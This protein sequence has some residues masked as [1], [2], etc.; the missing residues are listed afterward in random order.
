MA[1][2]KIRNL[3]LAAVALAALPLIARA[4]PTSTAAPAA[5][6]VPGWDALVDS[7][8]KLPERMLAKLPPAMQ[9]DPQV[10]QEVARLALE[11]VASSTLETIGADGDAPVFLPSIGQVLNVGQPNADTIY[12][13]AI[14]TPGASYRIRGKRGTLNLAVITQIVPG[15]NARQVLD[16]STLHA[17]K[18][19]RYDVLLSAKKPSGY[20][21]DWWELN[22]AATRLM[23][24]LVSSDWGNEEEPTLAIERA[25]R[26][27]GRPRP[28]AEALETKLRALPKAIDFISLMF[29]DHV[30]KLREEGWTNKLKVL[31]IAGTLQGQF[32]Y[33]G[34][35]DLADDEALIITSPVPR[36][37][38]YRSLILTNDIYETT[39]WINN[40]SSL[41]AA[42]AA[43]DA[44][45]K[46]RIVISARDP[47]VRNW[48]DTAG[49]PRGLI[50][51]RWMGCD[52]DPIP[53]VQKV[54]LKDVLKTLPA[55][56]ATVTPEER[57]KILSDRRAAYQERPQW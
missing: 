23:V 6:Q 12:R 24:R 48:M 18:D 36:T 13:A 28:S 43:P 47:G 45:G 10:R 4:Q 42:Q 56:V 22:P 32:Y 14:L 31:T 53:E 2:R 39:D 1:I 27:V 57:Q 51:G 25:D 55:G 41:N 38:R 3:G 16:L 21:G 9:A 19:G 50:Q 40:H 11:A 54:K 20:A 52:T 8:R 17:D 33:E 35:Y 46:L 49:Y 7:L 29:V 5:S 26:P 15:I 30:E 44:D 37:C 34:P